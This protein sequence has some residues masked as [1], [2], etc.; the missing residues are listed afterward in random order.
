MV[1]KSIRRQRQEDGIEFLDFI[2]CMV[3]S[4]TVLCDKSLLGED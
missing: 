1:I 4:G 2:D 3:D